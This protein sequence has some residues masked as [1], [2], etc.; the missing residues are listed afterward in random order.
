MKWWMIVCCVLLLTGCSAQPVWET[1]ED[2]IPT[3]NQR[4]FVYEIS[5]DL[6]LTYLDSGGNYSLYETGSVEIQTASFHASS[7]DTA[8]REISGFSAE[9]LNIVKTIRE[10]LPEYQ[11]A[12][13]SE[14][15][16]GGRLYRADLVMD[17]TACYAVVCSAPESESGFHEQAR[18]VFAAF[19]LSGSEEV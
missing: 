3:D 1:V 19:S 13:Y 15:E 18:Q 12:W 16:E 11:F 14:T 7:M 6:P 10:T 17:G 5:V 9:D 4:A 2:V 8:V